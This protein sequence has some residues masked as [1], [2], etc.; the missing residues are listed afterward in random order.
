MAKIIDFT[1]RTLF[2]HYSLYEFSFKPRIELVLKCEPFQNN[3]FNAPL[4]HLDEMKVVEA[5]EAE[6]MQAFL[7]LLNS[8][9]G[10]M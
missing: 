4:C 6:K 2:R 3:G 9:I 7:G 1:M 10:D 8:N 5:E